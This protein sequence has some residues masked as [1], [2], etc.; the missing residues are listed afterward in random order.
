M[1]S[2]HELLCTVNWRSSNLRDQLSPISD[3]QLTRAALLDK[4][5]ILFYR[6]YFPCSS[7]VGLHVVLFHTCHWF[8][9]SVTTA[10]IFWRKIVLQVENTN[11]V[12]LYVT[13][14]V[15]RL[16][17]VSSFT[18]Q[19]IFKLNKRYSISCLLNIFIKLL[20][21]YCR[22]DLLQFLLGLLSLFTF[23]KYLKGI[24]KYYLF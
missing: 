18:I 22:I 24:L 6:K 15:C 2:T 14:R 13:Y 4:S 16:K 1:Q 12:F 17:H 8:G 20:S 19:R 7:R 9:F 3:V 10:Y 23:S 5:S 11:R 21:I